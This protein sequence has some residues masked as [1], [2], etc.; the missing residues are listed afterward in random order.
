VGCWVLSAGCRAWVYS[1]GAG[2]KVESVWCG[3]QEAGSTV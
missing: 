3:M 1:E 2:C